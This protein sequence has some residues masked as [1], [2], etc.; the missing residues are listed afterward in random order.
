M[1][2]RV[3]IWIVEYEKEMKEDGTEREFILDVVDLWAHWWGDYIKR[4]I[5]SLLSFCARG[6]GTQ[7]HWLRYASDVASLLIS[8]D[9]MSSL[10][11]YINSCM[12]LSGF[13]PDIRPRARI[14]D[15]DSFVW[16]L[17]LRPVYNW[18]KLPN[19][20]YYGSEKEVSW[21]FKIYSSRVIN[22]VDGDKLV[23]PLEEFKRY[24]FKDDYL[25]YHVRVRF[26]M[27]GEGIDYTYEVL[28]DTHEEE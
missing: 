23:H 7:L 27:K 16:V 5:H 1:G 6:V 28:K 20:K 25:L 17:E 10:N 4:Y 18:T 22:W 24:D 13:R 19:G 9:F 8:W 14:R 26:F 15:V 12:H 11:D 2:N 21:D 3:E